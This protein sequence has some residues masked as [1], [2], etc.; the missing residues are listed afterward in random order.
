MSEI[1]EFLN[2]KITEKIYIL[3]VSKNSLEWAAALHSDSLLFQGSCTGTHK[4]INKEVA[5]QSR[6]IPSLISFCI[7]VCHVRLDIGSIRKSP[8]KKHTGSETWSQGFWNKIL[9]P[10]PSKNKTKTYQENKKPENKTTVISMDSFCWYGD[11][12]S[13]CLKSNFC[14]KI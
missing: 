14:I 7:E 1:H 11:P 5:A 3:R 12:H 9:L 10:F 13:G 6:M 8:A 2:N 4:S